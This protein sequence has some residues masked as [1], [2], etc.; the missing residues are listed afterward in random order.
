MLLAFVGRSMTTRYMH[1]NTLKINSVRIIKEIQ[2]NKKIA[3]G[4]KVAECS[5]F[6][7]PELISK[8]SNSGTNFALQYRVVKLSKC[9]NKF[10]L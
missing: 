10:H 8:C 7:P 1:K 3:K 9:I 4:G 5:V 2:Q 6:G